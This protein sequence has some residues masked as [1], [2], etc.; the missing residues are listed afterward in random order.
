MLILTPDTDR[1]HYYRLTL[2][3]ALISLLPLLLVRMET[4]DFV[5]IEMGYLTQNPLYFKLFKEHHTLRYWLL[6]ATNETYLLTGIS[7]KIIT[8]VLAVL[9]LLGIARETYTLLRNKFDFEFAPA[10]IGAWIILAFPVWHT[11][12]SGAVLSYVLFLWLFLAAVNQWV[13]KRY[14]PATIMFLFSL[15]YY[16]L[17]ALVVGFACCEL[18]LTINRKNALKKLGW[19]FAFGL[20]M[21]IWFAGIYIFG[22]IRTNPMEN[23]F[24]LFR[25]RSLLNYGI[26][27]VIISAAGYYLSTRIADLDYRRVFI[28]RTICFLVLGFFAGIAYWA[29]GKP[30]RFFA[31]GSY[32]ARHTFLTAL[33]FA[34][35]VATGVD[36]AWKQFNK[37]G[38][39]CALVLLFTALLVLQHQGMSHKA[40]ELVYRDIVTQEFK[41]VD[42]P[43]S[44]YVAIF[45][46]GFKQPRHIHEIA[47]AMSLYKAYGRAAWLLN[48]PWRR[49]IVPTVEE[50]V[51]MYKGYSVN[52]PCT[53]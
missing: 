35:A 5:G 42:A 16:S 37:K 12:V 4:W 40:A 14:I 25:F 34:L 36:L 6:L 39:M 9:A 11:L 17:Y 38:T 3:I 7:T 19:T 28:K 23:S 13:L 45:P 51:K 49:H 44:G 18:I 53:S 52:T 8:N 1:K 20:F 32:T 21:V 43:P 27:A 2:L 29:V 48:D 24:S 30:M 10:M 31:F 26:M 22:D 33:P 41:K 47:L 46:V 50:L 15:G